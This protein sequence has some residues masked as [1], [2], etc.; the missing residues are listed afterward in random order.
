MNGEM[1]IDTPANGLVT[2]SLVCLKCPLSMFNR[3]FVG[4]LIFLS[5]S[6]LDVILGTNWFE[7]NYVHINCYNKSVRFST[8]DEEKET[9]FLYAR[10]LNELMK[11]ES[12]V[13]ALMASLSIENQV[14]IDELPVVREFP[15]VFP[16]EIPDVPLER[17]VEYAIDLIPGTRPVSMAPYRMPH[18]N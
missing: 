1:V 12:P 14:S 18:L 4:D 17:E 6:G 7:S 11:D 10:Q 13:F 15:E 2:T 3:D 9:E 8:P 16:D 5:L